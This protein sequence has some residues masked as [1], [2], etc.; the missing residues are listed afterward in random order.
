LI[1]LGK[2][3]GTAVVRHNQ[4]LRHNRKSQGNPYGT[5]EAGKR[6]E[7]SNRRDCVEGKREAYAVELIKVRK[8]WQQFREVKNNY[9]PY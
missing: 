3:K 2:G 4:K 6:V 1:F 9:A 7:G 5:S 8:E